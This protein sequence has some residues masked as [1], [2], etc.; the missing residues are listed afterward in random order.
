MSAY[1]ILVGATNVRRAKVAADMIR[2]GRAVPAP[3]MAAYAPIVTMIDDIDKGGYMF[4]RLLQTI[5]AR[6][7]SKRK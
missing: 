2:Q 3:L 7:K 6:A 5:H 4:V 1:R